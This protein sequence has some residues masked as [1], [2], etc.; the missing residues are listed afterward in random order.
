MKVN[1]HHGGQRYEV[2]ANS[3]DRLLDELEARL[4]RP[5]LIAFVSGYV[6]LQIG[7]GR[8]EVSVAL[9][10]D[11]QGRPSWG[12]QPDGPGDK[13]ANEIVFFRSGQP[14]SFYSHAAIDPSVA[15]AV[16]REF[17]ANPAGPPAALT[18]R[19]EGQ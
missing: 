18:W 13:L 10:L 2:G 15:R 9:Y 16:A 6:T 5:E 14:H 4:T 1:V 3:V 8:A 12:S 11:D 7:V 19:L 17:V